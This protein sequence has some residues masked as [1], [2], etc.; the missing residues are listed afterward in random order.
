MRGWGWGIWMCFAPRHDAP[1]APW[2]SCSLMSVP[3]AVMPGPGLEDAAIRCDGG[4]PGKSP[5]ARHLRQLEHHLLGVMRHLGPD[6]NQLVPQDHER[7]VLGPGATLAS[8]APAAAVNA[9][10]SSTSRRA[11]KPRSLLT[12]M[13]WNSGRTEPSKPSSK[14]SLRASPIGWAFHGGA[15]MRRTP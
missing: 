12:V 1:I 7:A 5:G 14:A 8:V 4:S 3:V 2:F 10:A 11:S 15:Q 13:P 6:L 9:K